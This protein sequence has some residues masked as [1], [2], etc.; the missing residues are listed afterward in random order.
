MPAFECKI[1]A[2]Q[3]DVLAHISHNDGA[4]DVFSALL[5]ICNVLCSN[6][7]NML[8]LLLLKEHMSLR[9]VSQY[10]NYPNCHTCI[11]ILVFCP[12]SVNSFQKRTVMFTLPLSFIQTPLL[13]HRNIPTQLTASREKQYRVLVAPSC[14]QTSIMHPESQ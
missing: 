9:M 2:S 12:P 10:N 6:Y 4:D 13:P 3:G 11:R 8:I 14:G 1:A 7:A 5:T